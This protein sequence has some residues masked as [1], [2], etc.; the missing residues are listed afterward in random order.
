MVN[1]STKVIHNISQQCVNILDQILLWLF[2][3]LPEILPKLHYAM[4]LFIIHFM[5]VSSVFIFTFYLRIVCYVYSDFLF[6]ELLR[7]VSYVNTICCLLDHSIF[8]VMFIMSSCM[9]HS[10]QKIK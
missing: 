8:M 2:V 5:T 3:M 6:C 10:F 1:L 9:R 7:D 4:C